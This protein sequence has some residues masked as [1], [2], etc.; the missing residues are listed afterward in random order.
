MI[1]CTGK[2][3]LLAAL[4][5]PPGEEPILGVLR[6]GT[7]GN[8]PGD[9]QTPIPPNSLMT[10]LND[11]SG[12]VIEDFTVESEPGGT[13]MTLVFFLEADEGNG[14]GSVDYTEVGLYDTFDNLIAYETFPAK[15]KTVTKTL[16]T[17]WTLT[18]P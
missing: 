15:T 4:V 6:L 18:I 2:S 1:V 3:R 17:E 12:P 14:T 9:P 5:N 13:S 10:N 11:M 16:R 7:G 8:E